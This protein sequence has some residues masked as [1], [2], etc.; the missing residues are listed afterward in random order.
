MAGM[1]G[2][3]DHGE[4]EQSADGRPPREG[5]W[6]GGVRWNPGGGG[7]SSGPSGLHSETGHGRVPSRETT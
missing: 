4:G 2:E 7:D 6:G 1:L 5:D 3:K